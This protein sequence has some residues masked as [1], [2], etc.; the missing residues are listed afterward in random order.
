MQRAWRC[1]RPGL[2]PGPPAGATM[3]GGRSGTVPGPVLPAHAGMARSIATTLAPR[4]PRHCGDESPPR[5]S[6]EMPADAMVRPT[7]GPGG[8]A[9]VEAR[10]EIQAMLDQPDLAPI[11]ATWRR[12][13]RGTTR[14]SQVGGPGRSTSIPRGRSRAARRCTAQH[15]GTPHHVARHRALFQETLRCLEEKRR[16]PLGK[17]GQRLRP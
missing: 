13:A 12:S 9:R 15:P 5:R 14:C 3:R 6:K 2:S 11:A 7:I 16:R 8:M 17:E 10:A 1:W 4:A